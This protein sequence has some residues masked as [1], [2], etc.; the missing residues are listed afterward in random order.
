[1]PE[2]A[3]MD[4]RLSLEQLEDRFLLSTATT[5]AWQ[6]ADVAVGPNNLAGILWT[7]STGAAEVWNVNEDMFASADPAQNLGATAIA[8]AIGADG[9][10]RILATASNGSTILCLLNPDG[11]LLSQTTFAPI[12]G[13]T[14]QDI[15]VNS[16]GTII[17]WANANGSACLWTLNSS[18]SVTNAT[19]YGPFAGWTPIKIDVAPNGQMCLLWTS[20][21]GTAVWLLNADGSFN[22]ATVFGSI[23]GWTAVD[24]T[25]SSADQINVL[26]SNTSGAA[27]LWQ[28]TSSLGIQST[29]VYGPYAGW[30]AVALSADSTGDLTILWSNPT[31]VVNTSLWMVDSFGNFEG[32]AIFAFGS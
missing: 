14:A 7:S 9:I 12:A 13:W 17:L 25:E 31:S 22:S 4:T 15:A 32:A 29:E 5:P 3:I 16:S 30:S 26:W 1:M 18:L 8:E 28:L 20:S 21:S 27:A 10:T 19:V 6:V 2:E 24:I 23:S 11:S